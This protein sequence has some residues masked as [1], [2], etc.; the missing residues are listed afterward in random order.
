VQVGARRLR[1]GDLV[2][3][4]FGLGEADDA[5]RGPLRPK[6]VG[7]ISSDDKSDQPFMVSIGG[8]E[9]WYRA[10]ALQLRAAR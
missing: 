10:D 4:T 9:W 6:E 8:Q 3:L 2:E 7:R 5:M 1:V